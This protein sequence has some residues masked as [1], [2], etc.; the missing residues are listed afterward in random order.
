M[1]VAAAIGES[2]ASGRGGDGG[3][4]AGPAPIPCGAVLIRCTA[5]LLTRLGA[6]RR[7]CAASEA[8]DDDWYA[9][10]VWVDRRHCLLLVHAGTLFSVFAPG[11]N[12]ARLRHFEQLA[13][14]L[15]VDALA[16][17]GL[18]ATDFGVVGPQDV[19]VAATTSRSVLGHMNEMAFACAHACSLGGGLVETDVAELNRWLRRRLHR[20][21]REYVQPLE[22]AVVRAAGGG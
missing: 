19:R 16:G 11:V 17:E 6:E 14:D 1:I 21:G 15:V 18:A 7:P 2:A 4:S 8:D 12:G 10:L 5:K 22:L 13:C 9:N 3:G 20:R